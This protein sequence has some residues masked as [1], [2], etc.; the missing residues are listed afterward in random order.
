MVTVSLIPMF[1]ESSCSSRQENN[2]LVKGNS[3]E[4]VQF[5]KKGYDI[6]ASY[7]GYDADRDGVIT[8]PRDADGDGVITEAEGLGSKD[9]PSLGRFL[10]EQGLAI[11]KNGADPY[12]KDTEFIIPTSSESLQSFL[13]SSY[14]SELNSSRKA[15]VQNLWEMTSVSLLLK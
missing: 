9:Q 1:L 13:D 2:S 8:I 11:P 6:P 15:K 4:T 12:N 5:F 14:G 3:D 7:G 10:F